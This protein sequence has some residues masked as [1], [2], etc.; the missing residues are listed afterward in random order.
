MAEAKIHPPT[1]SRIADARAAGMAPRPVLAGLAGTTLA[2]SL[3]QDE[4]APRVW[5]HLRALFQMPLA[6]LADGRA[7][8]AERLAHDAVL[9]LCLELAKLGA[10]IFAAAALGVLWVQGPQFAFRWGRRARSRFTEPKPS[11][12]AAALFALSL[13]LLLA[14]QSSGVFWLEPP[15]LVGFISRYWRQLSLLVVVLA[16]VDAGFARARFFRALWLSRRELREE[17]R[18]AYGAPEL[19]AA[20]SRARSEHARSGGL[21]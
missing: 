11:R 15:A 3:V 17:Q 10:L 18:E 14:F 8:Q 6:A 4:L 19:R 1:P 21:P 7:Q 13:L 5:M 20:R 12:V 9:A 2:L 16:C